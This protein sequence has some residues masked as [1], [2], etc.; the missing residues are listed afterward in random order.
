MFKSHSIFPI[1]MGCDTIF[2]TVQILLDFLKTKST[3]TP[4]KYP[5]WH[6][7]FS[8]TDT[9]VADLASVA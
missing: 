7:S 1:F 9:Y 2:K 6:S 5:H 8:L 3:A 4:E